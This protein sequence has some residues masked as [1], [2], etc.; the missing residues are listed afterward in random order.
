MKTKKLFSIIQIIFVILAPIGS[1][2]VHPEVFAQ[3]SIS[4]SQFLLDQAILGVNTLINEANISPTS[5]KWPRIVGSPPSSWSGI[6]PQY[7]YGYYWGTA[8]IGDVLLEFYS[9]T[10]NETYLE[11]AE[12]AAQYL[13]KEAENFSSDATFWNTSEDQSSNYIGFK[14]GNV[15]IG[16]F[17]LHLYQSTQNI[18]YLET[19]RRTLK[20]L[21]HEAITN[22]NMSYWG[23]S[24]GD[25]LGTT[26]QTY[27]AAGVI[28]LFLDAASIINDSSEKW[29]DYAIQGARWIENISISNTSTQD[30]QLRAPWSPDINAQLT[31]LGSGNAGIGMAFLKLFQA[32]RDEMWLDRAIQVGNWLLFNQ[33]NG[34][35]VEGGIG[36]VTELDGRFPITGM[37]SGAAGIVRFLLD[38]YRES[39]EAAYAK[40]IQKALNWLILH[41]VKSN[42][43]YKWPKVVGGKDQNVYLS[44]WSY[45]TA[46]IGEVFSLAAE[47]FGCPF[48]K[49]ITLGAAQM[50][51][52]Q[53]N[54]YGLFPVA[55]G[56]TR[57]TS[58]LTQYGYH[59]S[60]FDGLAGIARF[61][62]NA[63]QRYDSPTLFPN[64]I[65]CDYSAL[66]ISNTTSVLDNRS[67]P[68]NEPKAVDII[69]SMLSLI[70]PVSV[71]LL[72]FYFQKRET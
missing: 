10:K 61:F 12:Q 23:I 25:T 72:V 62:L 33:N 48:F 24:I 6:W 7:Y 67:E 43:G 29:I 68:G 37:D 20:T 26:G 9:Y 3:G 8:G 40:S 53:R 5:A 18:T 38:L 63:A 31:G 50:L 56:E 1:L 2:H 16:T 47:A 69:L 65:S 42:E 17:L 22:S 60:F 11:F 27:G 21:E 51:A 36:Y 35:W 59:L 32:T 28:S 15:G 71:I 55:E 52:S 45:G 14:Y 70:L 13:I 54:Q 39:Q 19:A 57:L 66:P 34:S 44:G 30:A 64:V 49:E 58:F 4:S 46:G 41:K